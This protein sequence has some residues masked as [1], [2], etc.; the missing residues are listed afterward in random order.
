MTARDSRHRGVGDRQRAAEVVIPP[1]RRHLVRYSGIFGAASKHRGKL[2]ALVLP[3][4]DAEPARST[5]WAD[6]L[7]R[8]FADDVPQCPCGGRRSVIGVIADP[9]IARTLLVVL[10]LAHEPA[11]FAPARAPP[12]AELDWDDAS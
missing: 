9:A 12:D 6:L 2:R 1:P 7:R 10:G 8:V 4:D 3:R 5:P 11:A